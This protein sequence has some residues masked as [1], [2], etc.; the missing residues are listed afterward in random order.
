MISPSGASCRASD[1]FTTTTDRER[2]S[3]DASNPRPCS[4]RM[5]VVSK[6]RGDTTSNWVP[7]PRSGSPSTVIGA[8]TGLAVVRWGNMRA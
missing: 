4:T 1:S 8:S 7:I 3:S 2:A 6:K 5:P